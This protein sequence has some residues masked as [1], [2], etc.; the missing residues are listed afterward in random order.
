MVK[1][2]QST[3]ARGGRPAVDVD[4]DLSGMFQSTPARGGRPVPACAFR[5]R[6]VS[7]HART[8]RATGKA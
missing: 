2:F 3:P 7:I 4:M 8:R 6:F 5:S 1:K